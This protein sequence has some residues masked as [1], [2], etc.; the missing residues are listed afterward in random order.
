MAVIQLSHDTHVGEDGG[1]LVEV[2]SLLLARKIVKHGVV[3]P[4]WRSVNKTDSP[5]CL[6]AC[7]VH[8]TRCVNDQMPED[9]LW[10]LAPLLPRLIR[11]RPTGV[12]A[13]V[14][15][16]LAL[17]AARSVLDKVDPRL[18]AKCVQALEAAEEALWA[19]TVDPRGFDPWAPGWNQASQAALM[20]SMP[21]GAIWA[22][23]EATDP[24]ELPLWLSD[25]LDQFDKAL[26]EEGQL[27]WDPDAEYPP[28]DEVEAVVQAILASRR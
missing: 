24:D 7:V 26:A 16:R 23:V 17:W 9:E 6:S 4:D 3:S 19:D 15:R 20:Q 13:R 21:Q 10:R 1:C 12:D 27:A 2:A 25:F 8:A 11:A 22:A 28:D 18:H 5:P 14:L